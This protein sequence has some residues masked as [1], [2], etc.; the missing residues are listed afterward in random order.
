MSENQPS[1]T[2][3]P[4]HPFRLLSPSAAFDACCTRERRRLEAMD[5]TF[6]ADLFEKGRA[7]VLER[8]AQGGNVQ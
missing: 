5:T 8:L 3:Q 6:N 1:P 7:L 2:A 4:D